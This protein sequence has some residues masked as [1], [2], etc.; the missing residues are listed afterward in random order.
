MDVFDTCHEINDLLA[1]QDE[2]GARNA[3]IKLLAHMEEHDQPYPELLNH[4]IRN[5]GL[6]PYMKLDSGSWDQRY[7]HA[8]FEV[9]VGQGKAT[10]HREQSLVLSKLLK[11]SNLAV[12]AP[13]SFG[14]SF[15]IDAYIAMN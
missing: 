14:K 4:L 15:I 8:A 6:F 5:T 11:G 10:L 7:V 13:T 2:V 12:S 3:L 1:K 9:D